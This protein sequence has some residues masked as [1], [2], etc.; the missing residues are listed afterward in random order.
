VIEIRPAIAL[1]AIAISRNLRD[2]DR[3]VVERHGPAAEVIRI[4]IEQ[5]IMAL[6]AIL[7]GEIALLWG[8]RTP[9][10]LDDRAY[11]W[12]VGTP[13]IEQH[14]ITFLRHSRR[15]M[16]YM[17]SHFHLLYGE[18]E[19]DYLASQ[20]WLTWLGARIQPRDNAMVFQL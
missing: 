8:A 4:E 18:V 5:S 1:D 13:L 7:D 10:P 15:A 12:M 20:R 16:R 3:T 14:P 2:R 19:C 11:L 17:A 9:A 6:T